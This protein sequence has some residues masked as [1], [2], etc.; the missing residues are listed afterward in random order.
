V[1]PV[2]YAEDVHG[3]PAAVTVVAFE[4]G[5]RVLVSE[6]PGGGVDLPG[7]P[8]ARGEHW[9][10]AAGRITLE[11]LG[12]SARSLHPFAV[13]GDRLV[14][15][16]EVLPVNAVQAAAAEVALRPGVVAVAPAAA[17][18]LAELA[19]RAR[20]ELS[21]DA[22]FRD[23]RLLL[24]R[25]YLASSDPYEQSGKHGGAA[26]WELAR[27]FTAGALHR[28]GTF[29][30][31][32]CANGLLMESMA[33]WALADRGLRLEPYGLDISPDLAAL[34]RRRLP[35][36]ADRIWTGNAWDWEPPRRFDFVHALP[37]LVPDHL[38]SPWLGR[39][40]ARFLEP[41]GRLLLRWGDPYPAHP[42]R[43]TLRDVLAEAGVAAAGELV[44]VR[45][46]GPAVRV[47]WLEP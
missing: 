29:L 8:V 25:H 33:A 36:W 35:R 23:V 26:S 30:D 34:A 21:D 16:A 47:A 37:E 1:R 40:R 13:Q 19:V 38:R 45:P 10:V 24:E 22:W 44:Q 27:R 31:L 15:W 20:A 3:A 46:G 28:D 43:R 11:R 17:G 2:A 7:G 12:A 42:D 9:V 41:G 32:G 18:E 4:P 14:A 39:L 6:R 5:G